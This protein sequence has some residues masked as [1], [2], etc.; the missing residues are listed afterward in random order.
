MTLCAHPC[1]PTCPPLH[2][3]PYPCAHLCP[4]VPTYP[5]IHTYPRVSPV[6]MS[7]LVS[8]PQILESAVENART[9][10]QIDNARLAADDFR[11]K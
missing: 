11:V 7:V 9:V 8:P 2:E 4:S 5:Y 10:L 6:S 1:P 3:P